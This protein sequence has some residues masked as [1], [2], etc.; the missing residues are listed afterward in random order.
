MHVFNFTAGE[1]ALN[2]RHQLSDQQ[3]ARLEHARNRERFLQPLILIPIILFSCFSFYAADEPIGFSDPTD[4]VYLLFPG[5]ALLTIVQQIL[6]EYRFRAGLRAGPQAITGE[7]FR[8]HEAQIMLANQR[9]SVTEQQAFA[10]EQGA[11]YTIYF[12]PRSKMILSVH[13]HALENRYFERVD[14]QTEHLLLMKAFNFTLQDLTANQRGVLTPSQIREL[15]NQYSLWYR[16]GL[17]GPIQAP[18]K[19]CGMAVLDLHKVQYHSPCGIINID[20]ESFP[21][22]ENQFKMLESGQHYCI[23]YDHAPLRHRGLYRGRLLSNRHI[24]SIERLD[25]TKHR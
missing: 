1:M 23:Y 21:V 22:T 3:R 2:A 24:F 19:A 18:H 5:I 11:A 12:L 10:F 8:K 13:H 15:K 4:A 6:K 9:F 14:A 20:S 25:Q 7:V 17:L 16:R